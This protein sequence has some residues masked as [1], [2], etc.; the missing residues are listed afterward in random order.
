MLIGDPVSGLVEGGN[1]TNLTLLLKRPGPELCFISFKGTVVFISPDLHTKV[2]PNIKPFCYLIYV[3]KIRI[4]AVY[5]FPTVQ[6][7]FK[8]FSLS[9]ASEG[10][11]KRSLK[12]I[13]RLFKSS[14]LN[15]PMHY[16]RINR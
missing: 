13:F 1:P 16:S 14:G 15:P 7:N 12:F 8:E 4:K 11:K 6:C 5:N 9:Y 10:I 3:I 2:A